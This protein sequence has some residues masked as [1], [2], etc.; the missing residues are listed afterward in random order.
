MGG[1]LRASQTTIDTSRLYKQ[2][3]GT[4]MTPFRVDDV[5]PM[6]LDK[7][8][9]GTGKSV[10]EGLFQ[11]PEVVLDGRH[12]QVAMQSHSE[13]TKLEG[14]L[15]TWRTSINVEKST[16]VLFTRK[17]KFYRP[18]PLR[19]FGDQS[20]ARIIEIRGQSA[21][22]SRRVA[23]QPG[24]ATCLKELLN[25][26]ILRKSNI[27][28]PSLFP[29][30]PYLPPRLTLPGLP[31]VPPRVTFPE[32]PHV[33][34]RLTFPEHPSVPPRLTLPEHPSVPPRLTL[35]EHSRQPFP[36]PYP[37]GTWQVQYG[38][39]AVVSS[40]EK[41]DLEIACGRT[42]PNVP[43]TDSIRIQTGF[44]Q[45]SVWRALLAEKK[46]PKPSEPFFFLKPTSSYIV[47]GQDV[48]V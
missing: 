35:P 24:C 1:W 21:L 12:I 34:P 10:V 46:L 7:R 30:S 23:T 26:L 5:I 32:L 22:V 3:F 11:L 25:C 47:E 20:P 13:H 37:H 41:L 42:I 43:K 33:P 31:R 17:R 4:S 48:K 14:W 8:I 2:G 19:L 27:V 38:I 39:E 45:D 16:V 18:A 6:P 29:P 15:T 44:I 9:G 40:R 28:K 36:Y